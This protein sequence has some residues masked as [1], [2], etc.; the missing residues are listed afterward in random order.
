MSQLA[1]EISADDHA[2]DVL[3]QQWRMCVSIDR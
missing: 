3:R 2:I 1:R